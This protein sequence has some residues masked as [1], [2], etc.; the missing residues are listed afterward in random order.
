[1]SFSKQYYLLNFR[2]ND[3]KLGLKIGSLLSIM[4]LLTAASIMVVKRY[5]GKL[6][7]DTKVINVAGRQ[8]ML[9]QRIALLAEMTN[10]D[11]PGAKD[12]L[13]ETVSLYEVSHLA[14]LDGGSVP[15]FNN[16]VLYG[17]ADK[18]VRALGAT[19][20]QRWQLY[21]KAALSL[22]GMVQSSEANAIT[23]LRENSKKMLDL[24]IDFVK[25]FVA[26]SAENQS[27]MTVDLAAITAIAIMF[28]L[29][30]FWSSKKFILKPVR[31]IKTVS[32]R[33][34]KGDLET[35]IHYRGKDEIG[36]M[37]RSFERLVDNLKKASL[38][39]EEIGKG[40]WDSDFRALGQADQL[41]TALL[42][43]R[44]KLSLFITEINS[45]VNAAGSKGEL[46]SRV[47]L[48]DQDGAW[49][50][51][52][53]SVNQLLDT[54]AIPVRNVNSIVNAMAEG[55]LTKRY[56]DK[57]DG[58]IKSLSVN[59]NK[60]LD[61]LNH[62]MHQISDS[63]GTIDQSAQEMSLAS[64]E[65][66]LNTGEIATAISQISSGAQSQVS[67]VDESSDLSE[68][69][70]QSSKEMF[71]RLKSINQV[72]KSGA[73]LSN[74]GTE[75]VKDV[76]DRISE[77]SDYSDKT[78]QSIR[79]LTE[80]S[81]EIDRV[82][83][84]ITDISAQTNLLALN[85]AIEAAQAGDA[86]RG[87]AVVAEEIRKLAEDSRK[88]AKEIEALIADVQKDTDGAS[89]AIVEMEKSV[90][91]GEEASLKVSEV[92]NQI[93]DTN[94]K[95]LVSSEDVINSTEKQIQDINEVV[96]ITENIVIIAEQSAAG[97]EEIA[98]SAAE[99]SSGME[100][101]ASKSKRLTEISQTLKDGVS[102]FKLTDHHL[103]DVLKDQGISWSPGQSNGNGSPG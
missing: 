10:N 72:A 62:F 65:M 96:G 37:S 59:L 7:E 41:G 67:K 89:T 46:D 53:E 9:T 30:A 64:E 98:S 79:V 51:L 23:Y 50:Q 60:A 94:S 52:S 75:M 35:T 103:S 31:E 102:R 63:T 28:A 56:T 78:N 25:L 84:V 32:D 86:G 17:T 93:A 57:A 33:V 29:A 49:R 100:T 77:I 91:S 68:R 90:K 3:L 69:M 2:I 38:F 73:Q 66:N 42:S 81:K 45:V 8:R 76:V 54:I 19:I 70:L 12:N 16:I 5:Q 18:E 39:A 11:V 1:M 82:L 80:R 14:L 15:G 99:L 36:E 83:G 87:F 43:M 92:F 85:A 47:S 97:T 27:N 44:R 6:A 101:Y 26:I 24:N 48:A 13:K 55:D 4:V 21:K 40:N 22:T 61:N 71:D 34:S 74:S 58:E 88:S 20:S 95:A